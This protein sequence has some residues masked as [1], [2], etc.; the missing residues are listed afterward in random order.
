L[1]VLIVAQGSLASRYGGGQIYVL[2]LVREMVRQNVELFIL[3]T[4]L[5][6]VGKISQSKINMDGVDVTEFHLKYTN[7]KDPERQVRD[8][9]Q[10]VR[11]DIIHANS[12]KEVITQVCQDENIPCIVTAHHGGIVCPQGALLNPLDE[13]CS[14][15]ATHNDCLPCVLRNIR[16]GNYFYKFYRYLPLSTRLTLGR[17]IAKLPF[18]Y[19]ITPWFSVSL[20][21]QQKKIEWENIC[22]NATILIAP[23]EAMKVAMIRN[24]ADPEKVRVVRHGIPLLKRESVP[25]NYNNRPVRFIYLGRINRVKGLHILLNAFSRLKG[26]AE[27]TIIGGAVTHEEIR[28]Q[29]MLKKNYNQLNIIWT[30][31]LSHDKISEQIIKGDVMVHPALFLEVYG[32]TIAESISAGR[33]VIATRCGG[34]EMQIQDGVNGYLVQPNNTTALTERMQYLV[35]HPEEIIRLAENIQQPISIEQHVQELFGIYQSLIKTTV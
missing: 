27:I 26:Q 33:P 12:L 19:F 4:T 9:L 20:S 8:V 29:K 15:R 18:I 1:K 32:L 25:D 22:K 3:S 24:G 16:G 23:S 13:I 30:G 34:P 11:P 21:I 31:N 17:V 28:Y 7:K 35:D 6:K 14:I 2:N 5:N 10:K